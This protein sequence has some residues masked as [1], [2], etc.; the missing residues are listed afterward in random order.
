MKIMLM[1]LT[2]VVIRRREDVHRMV[3]VLVLSLAF[4]GVKGGIFTVRE[5]GN[6]RVWG[7]PAPSSAAT[8]RS[9]WR[10]SS[11]FR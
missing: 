3:W 2:M 4:Y 6:F 8:T 7:R 11:P 10:S 1:S 5:G 9:R